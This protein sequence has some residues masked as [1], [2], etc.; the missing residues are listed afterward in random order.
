M[1]SAGTLAFTTAHGMINRVHRHATN[2]RSLAS[3]RFRPALPNL[4]LAYSLLPTWPMQARHSLVE[5]A[6]FAGGQLD[7]HMRAFLGHDLRGSTSAATICAPL[8]IFHLHIVDDGTQGILNIG[9]QLP[10]L[11]STSSPAI[12]WSPQ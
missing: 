4:A 8:P 7:Q 9:R 12:T 6:H 10:G 2:M 11:I 3:Q 1:P 5:L